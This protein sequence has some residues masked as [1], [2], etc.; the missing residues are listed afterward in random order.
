MPRFNRH[1]FTVVGNI[2]FPTDMLRYDSCHPADTESA[3]AISSSFNR[4]SDRDD[5][6]NNITKT[7]RL[8]SYGETPPT[9]ARWSSFNWRVTDVQGYRV[10]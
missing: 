8:I 6:G 1:H 5:D 4:P 10:K 3:T 9:E 7:V 2:P